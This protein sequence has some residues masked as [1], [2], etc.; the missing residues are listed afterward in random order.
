MKPSTKVFVLKR[1]RT[2]TNIVIEET[3]YKPLPNG[4]MPNKEIYRLGGYSLFQPV[5]IGH[6]VELLIDEE[7]MFNSDYFLTLN[8]RGSEFN[9]YGTILIVGVDYTRG[10]YTG[11]TE[12]QVE[13]ISKSLTV[14]A[15][16][17]KQQ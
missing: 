7:G 16:G 13:Y 9:L 12:E 14:R 1:N 15:I 3:S 2:Y 4:S 11:L 6:G 8:L 10:L 17:R 5:G